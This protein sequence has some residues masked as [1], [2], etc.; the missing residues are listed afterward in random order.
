MA[1]TCLRPRYMECSRVREAGVGNDYRGLMSTLHFISLVSY[2]ALKV[3]FASLNGFPRL[4][5]MSLEIR[6]CLFLCPPFLQSLRELARLSLRD[7]FFRHWD[8]FAFGSGLFCGMA[9]HLAVV[10]KGRCLLCSRSLL[11]H[12]SRNQYPTTE[13]LNSLLLLYRD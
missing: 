2:E 7:P 13:D 9:F 12:D 11:W 3:S 4:G 8:G 5:R 6:T 1:W 10:W